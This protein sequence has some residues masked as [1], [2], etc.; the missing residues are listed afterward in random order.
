MGGIFT[1]RPGVWFSSSSDMISCV[2]S[3]PA[4]A[5]VNCVPMFTI[6]KTGAIMKAR[7]ML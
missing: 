5:S 3:R 7:N 1:V 6:W 2:R 4:N